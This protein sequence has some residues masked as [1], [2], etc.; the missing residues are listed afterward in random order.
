MFACE[1]T[2]SVALGLFLIYKVIKKFIIIF[3]MK[4]PSLILILKD[5]MA[6]SK[7]KYLL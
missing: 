7:S 3:M 4:N 5:A 6:S 1:N 2:H